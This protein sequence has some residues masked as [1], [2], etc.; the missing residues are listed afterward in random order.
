MPR[1]TPSSSSKSARQPS[2][3]GGNKRR[4]LLPPSETEDVSP[5]WLIK[6]IAAIIGFSFVCGYLTLCYLFYQGQWQLVLHPSRT[7]KFVSAGEVV[8][9]AADESAIPQLAGLWIPAS[10]GGR[11]ADY[12][13]L[14]LPSGDGSLND[15]DPTLQALHGLGINLFAFDYRGYGQSAVQHPSQQS[16][17]QDAASAWQYLTVSRAVPA[18]H[19]LVYGV[20]VGASL[21][22]QL[23]A[24]HPEAPA[25]LLESLR[26]DLL[27][28]PLEDPRGNGV[29]VRLLFHDRFPLAEPLTSLRTPK[30]FLLSDAD[31]PAIRSKGFADGASSPKMISNLH[32][33]DLN[34]LIYREQIT[35]FLDQYLTQQAPPLFAS[36]KQP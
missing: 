21:A 14:C 9:F 31:S 18:N 15:L 1:P 33:A 20:G 4:S 8:R 28:V 32:S 26:G 16:M 22:V 34:G 2:A 24:N 36:P 35:R 30:L 19:I 13:L 5:L 25:V 11:Y 17:A 29:P 7:D 6:A 12:T 10:P 3:P 23:A 27:H